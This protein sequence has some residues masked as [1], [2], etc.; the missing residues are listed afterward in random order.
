MEAG[1]APIGIRTEYS[2]LGLRTRGR[3]RGQQYSGCHSPGCRHRAATGRRFCKSCQAT[4]DKVRSE[5]ASAKPRGRKPTI[6][7]VA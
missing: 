6:R 5:L 2:G 4:L 3:G 7:K 1:T